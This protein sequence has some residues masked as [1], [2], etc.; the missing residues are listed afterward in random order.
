[1]ISPLLRFRCP[2]HVKDSLKRRTSKGLM[3]KYIVQAL[4]EKFVRDDKKLIPL[5]EKDKDK[6]MIVSIGK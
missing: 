6:W 1:M 5:S 3:S 2:L 4:E